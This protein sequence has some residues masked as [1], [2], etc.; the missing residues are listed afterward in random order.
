MNRSKNP[1]TIL[2][3]EDDANIRFGLVELL[4][5]EGFTVEAC[6]RGDEAPAAAESGRAGPI[7]A[8]PA[9]AGTRPGGG[10]RT[11]ASSSTS[12]LTRRLRC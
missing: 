3:V 12:R 8:G 7:L 1:V 10:T 6:E 4:T 5:S 9:Q 11:A 2:V